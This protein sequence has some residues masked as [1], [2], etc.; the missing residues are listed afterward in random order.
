VQA[1]QV[2]FVKWVHSEDH[3]TIFRDGPLLLA[4]LRA[5][6]QAQHARL[7][8]RPA[9]RMASASAAASAS[10]GHNPRKRIA[11]PATAEEVEVCPA[12]PRMPC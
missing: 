8:P 3:S 5:Q 9:P 11:A 6:A 2:N 7:P 12:V 10:A 1:Q 4:E